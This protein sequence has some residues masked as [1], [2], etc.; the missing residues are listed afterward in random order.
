MRVLNILKGIIIFTIMMILTIVIQFNQIFLIAKSTNIVGLIIIFFIILILLLKLTKTWKL[1]L[2][3]SPFRVKD[4]WLI[5]GAAIASEIIS[6]S[7]SYIGLLN[8]SQ[9][10]PSNELIAERMLSSNI[11]VVMIAVISVVFMGPILEEI[12]FRE[13]IYQFVSRNSSIVIGYI[14]TAVIFAYLHGGGSVSF[15]DYVICSFILTYV[16]QRTGNIYSS[17]ACHQL[18]NLIVTLQLFITINI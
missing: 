2:I 9:Q 10:A 7:L 18:M 1:E 6:M 3:S 16:F 8:H 5:V 17:I 11:W 13:M 15:V 14:L 4:I 12:V